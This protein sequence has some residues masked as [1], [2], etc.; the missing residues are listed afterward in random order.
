MKSQ[1]SELKNVMKELLRRS[2]GAKR[3]L[4]GSIRSVFQL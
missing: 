4:W 1:F 2:L 3:K